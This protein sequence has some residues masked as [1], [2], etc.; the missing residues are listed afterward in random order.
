M[1]LQNLEDRSAVAV[2]A[3]ELEESGDPRAELVRAQLEGQHER[4]RELIKA[5][6]SEWI[7]SIAPS[8]VLLRWERGYV[9]EAAFRKQQTAVDI[10]ELIARPS[11]RYLRRLSL[12]RFRG[13]SLAGLDGL[14]SL[15]ELVLFATWP[16]EGALLLGLEAL[17]LDL[18][19]DSSALKTL[20]APSLKSLHTRCAATHEEQLLR[21]LAGSRWW[22]SLTKWTHRVQSREGLATLLNMRPLVD[23]GGR[24]FTALCEQALFE[25]ISPGVKRALPHAEFKLTPMPRKPFDPENRE[26]PPGVCVAPSQTD[27]RELPDWVVEKRIS[28]QGQHDYDTRQWGPG[29]PF[30]SRSPY[31][32]SCGWCASSETRH[33]FSDHAESYAESETTRYHSWCYECVQC[34]LFTSMSSVYT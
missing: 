3:D 26:G 25:F 15:R 4:A 31:F 19:D 13:L 1:A 24:G 10:A 29:V 5:H 9:T 2:H 23:R 34:G 28:V 7:G 30:D 14:Q 17:T 12:E 18:H 21:T 20:M 6:W 8:D 11:L 22:A 27:F 33:I 16:L 32:H